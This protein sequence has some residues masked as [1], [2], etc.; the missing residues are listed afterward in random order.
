MTHL[1]FNFF[2]FSFFN[3]FLLEI[4]FIISLLIHFFFNFL[5]KCAP[6]PHGG[7][8]IAAMS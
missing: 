3:F 5:L 6:H 1:F 7:A 2:S 4:F 8:I